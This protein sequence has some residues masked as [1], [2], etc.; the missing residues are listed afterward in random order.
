MKTSF[1]ILCVALLATT[2]L[3]QALG[4]DLTADGGGDGDSGVGVKCSAFAAIKIVVTR[5]TCKGE[6]VA[7]CKAVA[8]SQS[9][10]RKAYGTWWNKD[11]SGECKVVRLKKA[12]KAVARA[13]AA[14][15]AASLV[16]V[17][18]DGKGFA[19]GASKAEGEAFA[20]SFARAIAQ[21][22]VDAGGSASD[23][24][25]MADVEATAGAIAEAAASAR[26][27]ACV[28]DTG[29]R[30]DFQY[31]MVNQITDAIATAFVDAMAATC[32]D[33]PGFAGAASKCSGEGTS[34]TT[35]EG[36]EAS[37]PKGATSRKTAQLDACEK[38]GECCDKEHAARFCKPTEDS[39]FWQRVSEASESAAFRSWRMPDGK[40][41]WCYTKGPVM[42]IT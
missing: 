33:K 14:A 28:K 35:A 3:D 18:C 4:R 38:A 42:L 8:S 9:T 6:A 5:G 21:A 2:V 27:T 40:V 34:E 32:S 22:A 13:T 11:G 25:C 1:Q 23:A 26:S 41:C 31:A 20:V 19:C 29:R 10:F 24:F 17:K 36:G 39:A 15:F 30:A 7:D 16:K 12:A 37:S